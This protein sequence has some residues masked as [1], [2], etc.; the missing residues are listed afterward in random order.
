MTKQHI[1]IHIGNRLRQRRAMMG[2]NQTDVAKVIG[3]TFQQIQ[4][5]E[6]GSNALS[7][8]RLVDFAQCMKVSVP[9]FFEGLE[10]AIS[11]KDDVGS[12]DQSHFY[13]SDR[14]SLEFM[15]AFKNIPDRNLRKRLADLVR[16]I[17]DQDG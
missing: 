7:A 16:C 12:E 10:G 3:V 11:K 15:K 2:L 8:S 9:Y 17:C 13:A 6:N 4:K 14:E 1:N 5:Y